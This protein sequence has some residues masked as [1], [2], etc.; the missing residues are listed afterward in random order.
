MIR[1]IVDLLVHLLWAAF[2]SVMSSV[3]LCRCFSPMWSCSI[4]S[5]TSLEPLCVPFW[6]FIVPLQLLHLCFWPFC[7]CGQFTYRWF[8]FMAFCDQLES[9]TSKRENTT[10]SWSVW[11]SHWLFIVYL[12]QLYFTF[13]L[14][15]P[16]FVVC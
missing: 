1:F 7:L 5:C 8:R 4:Y 13:W 9:F 11:D 15:F 2:G 10:S 3:A 6:S 12:Q 16:A 14:L